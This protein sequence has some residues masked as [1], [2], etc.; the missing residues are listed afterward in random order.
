MPNATVADELFGHPKGLIVCFFAEMWERF[1]FYGMKALLALY[2]IQHHGYTDTLSLSLIGAYGGLVYATPMLG[3]LIADRWLGTRRAVVLGGVLLTLGHLGMS[4]EGHQ[5]R[6][7][8]GVVVR[9]AFALSVL[10]ASLAL[11]ATGVGF[12]KP[13][14]STLVGQ[15]YPARDPRRDA[16]F[17]LFVA[18]IGLGSLFAS[19][20]CGY[21]GQRYGW[22]YGFGAAGIGMVAG[23]AVF[24]G[25]RRHLGGIGGAPDEA[26]L[27]AR[28]F[29]PL[30]LE[31]AIYLGAFAALPLLWL[32]MQA[33]H[34]VLW[35]QLALIGLWMGW[36]VWYLALRCPKA[37]RGRMLACVHY[38]VVGLLFY[39]LYEQSYGSWVLFTERLLDKDFLPSWVVHDGTPLPWTLIPMALSPLLVAA[40]LRSRGGRWPAVSLL[41]LLAAMALAVLHDVL[42]LPQTAGS[43]TFLGPLFIVL[44]SP[45]FAAIWPWLAR[46]GRDPSKALKSALGLAFAGLAFVPLMMAAER[47]GASG[48]PAAVWWLVAAYLLLQLGEVML[49]PIGL[50]AV[51]ALSVPAVGGV[52]M[53]AWWLGTSFS[54]QAAAALGRLAA[55]DLLPGEAVD[56][57]AAAARYGALFEQLLWLGLGCAALALLLTPLIA[58]WGAECEG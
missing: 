1:S 49:Y 19:V 5:A 47:A 8:D 36:L 33:G 43:L 34:A 48:K 22:Q 3:G 52:M 27:K 57:V 38:I 58:R 50:S 46:R 41:V 17:T 2:L 30:T 4:I 28:V 20:V 29:G 23:L 7:I 39:A 6:V 56:P 55:I 25:G 51:S 24:V 53:G 11:I 31:W 14:I 26:R 35:F 21:L 16:G 13:N 42:V 18:G 9:D 37:A 15:L 40:V 10:F 32:L 45:L 44:L 54:E 12:L